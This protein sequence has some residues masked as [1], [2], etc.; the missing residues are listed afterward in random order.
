MGL[1]NNPEINQFDS[2]DRAR[3]FAFE[4]FEQA[5][6][7]QEGYKDFDDALINYRHS[8]K[9]EMED[10]KQWPAE[11]VAK[12]L[13]FWDQIVAS[14]T[15]NGAKDLAWQEPIYVPL[16]D[17]SE[18]EIIKLPRS[19]FSYPEISTLTG[20]VRT[21][22]YNNDPNSRARIDK[23][24]SVL[25]Q[26]WDW[27]KEYI[28]ASHQEDGAK[29]ELAQNLERLTFDELS[30]SIHDPEGR[31]DDMFERWNE[32]TDIPSSDIEEA[33]ML[34][35]QDAELYQFKID[36]YDPS[37]DFGTFIVPISASLEFDFDMGGLPSN[38]YSDEVDEAI[39]LFT[40]YDGDA[41]YL[42][43]SETLFDM[44]DDAYKQIQ[45]HMDSSTAVFYK[46]IGMR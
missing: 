23:L 33:M 17:L 28:R 10:F 35:L 34:F 41:D 42:L 9:S 24:F 29:D 12:G 21:A 4:M 19:A 25:K 43:E 18:E 26:Q 30:E 36:D 37:Y 15:E 6:D 5:I 31:L 45:V 8:L 7:Q 11:E 14:S 32:T 46:P 39:R 40:D 2:K 44:R 1:K 16:E 22:I 38:I 27:H 20:A 3:A 13:E